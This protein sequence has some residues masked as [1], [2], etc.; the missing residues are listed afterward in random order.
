MVISSSVLLTLLVLVGW[1]NATTLVPFGQFTQDHPKLCGGGPNQNC[2]IP[3]EL[4]VL[5]SNTDVKVRSITVYGTLVIRPSATNKALVVDT[6]F[7]IA[8]GP[9]AVI[10]ITA[11]DPT[12]KVQ[13]YLR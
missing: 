3:A 4:G 8:S 1:A 6:A 11:K 5:I 10:N 9:Q 12:T 7:L 2:T 13:I